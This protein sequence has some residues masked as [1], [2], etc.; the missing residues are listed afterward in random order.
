MLI[1]GWS[2][3][4]SVSQRVWIQF[5]LRRM[6]F[7]SGLGDAGWILYGLVRAMKP[8]VCVEIGSARGKS[9][10]YIAWAL[11]EN[12]AGRL[13]AIDPH[14]PTAWNDQGSV[15]T[16]PIL[17]RH[18]RK[19]GLERHVSIERKTSQEAVRGWGRPIDLLFIDGDH[20][21]EGVRRDWEL[22]SPFVAPHGVVVFHDTGW[23]L[24]EHHDLSQREDMGVPQFVD[25]LRRAGHPV[26]TLQND[27]G[28]SLVQV[29]AGGIPLQGPSLRAAHPAEG[30]P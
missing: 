21:Y 3:L 25:G 20:S 17:V 19:L 16:Y 28:V 7:Q 30:T 24:G 26:V 10:C 23:G 14:Q 8:T 4:R 29:P 22:F 12:G 11:H 5:H 2:A 27:Y 6:D 18:L 9:S 13:W 15:N 1:H